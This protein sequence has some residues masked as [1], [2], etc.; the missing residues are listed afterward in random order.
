MNATVI[1]TPKYIM[2]NDDDIDMMNILKISVD[3]SKKDGKKLILTKEDAYYSLT[4]KLRVVKKY[5]DK[6]K[7]LQYDEKKEHLE[8]LLRSAFMPH[9]N[10]EKHNDILK[11]K[12][13]P[14][15][16]VYYAQDEANKLVGVNQSAADQINI[17]FKDNKP[18]RVIFINNLQGTMFPMNQI[19]HND[20][21][22]KD[23]KWLIDARPKSKFDILGS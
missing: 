9:I 16:N 8:S 4:N 18:E 12:G 7:K 22:V 15:Q 2:Y 1:T 19:N 11:T 23:F 20:L 6:N 13:S 3:L 10:S 21:K 14:A 5:I 17:E